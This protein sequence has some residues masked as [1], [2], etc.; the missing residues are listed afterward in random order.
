[1][2]ENCVEIWHI[3]IDSK[4]SSSISI[5]FLKN[6]VLKPEGVAKQGGHLQWVGEGLQTQN[7]SLGVRT[8]WGER[9]DSRGGWQQRW[10]LAYTQEY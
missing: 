10:G 4:H 5:C 6:S 7:H 2:Q 3:C 8:R 9:G 1:M